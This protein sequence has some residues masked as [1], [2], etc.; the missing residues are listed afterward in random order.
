MKTCADAAVASEASS[1]VEQRRSREL[2]SRGG[3]RFESTVLNCSCFHSADLDAEPSFAWTRLKYV[4]D[5]FTS[6]CKPENE[7]ARRPAPGFVGRSSARRCRSV[8]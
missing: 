6:N 3:I 4:T 5:D 2:Q 7:A 1:H 8:R